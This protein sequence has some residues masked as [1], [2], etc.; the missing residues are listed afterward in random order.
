LL[1]VGTFYQADMQDWRLIVVPV[2]LAIGY[3]LMIER[4]AN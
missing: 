1:A 4:K 3:Y 2:A